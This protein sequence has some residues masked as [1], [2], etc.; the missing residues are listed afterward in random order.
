MTLCDECQRAAT[1]A[2]HCVYTPA[3][4]CKAR[5]VAATPRTFQR[6]AFDAVCNGLTPED[7]HAVRE[8]AHALIRAARG[9][10]A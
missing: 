9:V 10:E 7:A 1:D 8:R 2:L 5:A 3:L 6:Q 4:C